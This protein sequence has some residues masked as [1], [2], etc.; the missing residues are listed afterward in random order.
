MANQP[1]TNTYPVGVYQWETT[2]PVEGGVGGIDN[3]PILELANRTNWLKSRMP[4][5]YGV[6][7]GLI[8]ADEAV[9]HAYTVSGDC[10]SAT[11]TAT[12]QVGDVV[13]VVFPNAMANTNYKVNF[14]YESAVAFNASMGNFSLRYIIINTT[15]F[16]F[17]IEGGAGAVN[18]LNIEFE[19][20]QK[21]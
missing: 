6:V 7:E 12:I 8:I 21:F 15:T 1:E 4:R 14:T 5:N 10:T 11:K 20:V 17:Y 13:R 3:K 16:D 9:S 2:D 18:P 19:T